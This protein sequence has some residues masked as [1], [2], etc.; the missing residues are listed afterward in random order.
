MSSVVGVILS[1]LP[2]LIFGG[3]AAVMVWRDP[4]RMRCAIFLGLAL[5]Q[6]FLTAQPTFFGWLERVEGVQAPYFLLA[7]FLLAFLLVLGVAAFLSWAGLVLVVREGLSTSHLLSL[8]LGA[9]ILL[10]VGLG[11]LT[12][13]RGSLN[14]FVYLVLLVFPIATFAFI[15]FS[16]LLYSGLYGLWAR[17]WA[18]PGEV[19]V[20]LGSGLMGDRVPPLL[21]R[22][23]DLGIATYLRARA[24]W[25]SPLLVVSGGRGSDEDISEAEAMA[26]YVRNHDAWVGELV[27]E[28]QSAS[29]EQNIRFTQQ[30]VFERGV[31]GPWT[32]VTS[33]FHAFRAAML[34]SENK[35]A[36][37]AVG[38]RSVRYFWASA[39]LRELIAILAQFPRWTVGATIVSSLPLLAA[40]ALRLISL[41]TSG[42]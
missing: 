37:N 41:T 21:A 24:V 40:I 20:V 36:G 26:R 9:G 6:I 33:D 22:R 23:L 32:A 25:P 29:T 15:L 16:Y 14:F 28:D 31:D 42:G 2:A 19:V 1:W 10:Y 8:S 35:I 12:A 17:R 3:T 27:L 11:V 38:A 13:L 34:L 4:R 7:F 18:V 30:V 39:K 5:V